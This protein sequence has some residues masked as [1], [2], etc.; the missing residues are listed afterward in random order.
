MFIN[1][2]IL[3]SW[4]C[5]VNRLITN[6]SIGIPSPSA[7]EI[8]CAF[9]V[10]LSRPVGQCAEAKLEDTYVNYIINLCQNCS[11]TFNKRKG[12]IKKTC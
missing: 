3:G 4:L 11:G 12:G 6:A 1:T 5:C 8:V 7:V 10:V 2:I 9:A